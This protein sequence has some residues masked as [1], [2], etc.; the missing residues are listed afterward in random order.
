MKYRTLYIFVEGNDDERFFNN[1]IVPKLKK[2]Y[3]KIQIVKY[4]EKP[5]KFE[6]VEKYVN[7][8]KSM[9]GDYILVTDINDS[10]CVTAKKNKIIEKANKIDKE[11]I[12][13]VV[14]EIE[15]W[16]LAGLDD[17]TSRK[18]GIRNFS[19]TDNIT[20]QQFNKL[21]SKNFDSRIY[22]MLEILKNFSVDIAKRKNKSFRY[23]IE[24][25]DC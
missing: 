25:Y 6:Y 13:V 4:A 7:S 23:F 21:I 18:L 8:I 16:Y 5:K 14:K 11:K 20:K 22:F 3:T 17:N 12:I 1:V 2:K 19:E 9:G 24:K 10:P 15:S